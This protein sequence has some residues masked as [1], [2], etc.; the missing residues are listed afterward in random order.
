MRTDRIGKPHRPVSNWQT[1]V[2]TPP[3]V[4]MKESVTIAM[5]TARTVPVAVVDQVNDGLPNP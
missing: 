3:Q 1:L 2:V 5:R 4:G